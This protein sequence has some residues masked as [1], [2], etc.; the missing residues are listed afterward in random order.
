M[1]DETVGFMNKLRASV[2]PDIKLHVNSMQR[3]PAAQARTTITKINLGDDLLAL[4]NDTLILEALNAVGVTNKVK[5]DPLFTKSGKEFQILTKVYADQMA[6]GKY[7]SKHLL[8]G[9]IDIK[10]VKWNESVRKDN[11]DTVLKHA[12]KLGAKTAIY[13]TTPPHIHIGL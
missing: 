7:I 3:T 11:I 5:P 12:K 13:E 2:P 1:S 6:R 8:A 9:A 4:Y 10:V